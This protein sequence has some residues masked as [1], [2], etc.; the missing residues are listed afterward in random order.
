MAASAFA[1]AVEY[2]LAA[3][4][5]GLVVTSRWRRRRRDRQLIQLQGGEFRRDQVRHATDVKRAVFYSKRIL[6]RIAESGIK[7]CTGATHFRHTNV[8]VP[9]R[10]RAKAGPGMQVH[11]SETIGRGN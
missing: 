1:F 11:A 7:E 3:L 2:D 9:V 6:C 4:G 5:G 10:H 8:C